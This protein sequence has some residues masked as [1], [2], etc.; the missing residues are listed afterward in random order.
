METINLKESA[1]ALMFYN[2]REKF[3]FDTIENASKFESHLK[4]DPHILFWTACATGLSGKHQQAIEKLEGLKTNHRHLDYAIINALIWLHEQSG[5]VDNDEMEVLERNLNIAKECT[6][7]EA[8]LL[9]AR[10]FLLLGRYSETIQNL[11]MTDD[12][13]L[14]ENCSIHLWLNLKAPDFC[15][16]NLL[17]HKKTISTHATNSNIDYLMAQA[18]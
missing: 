6:S 3:Y 17:N 9:S 7:S 14:P 4:N 10:L 8:A 18:K 16:N 2:L 13:E 11:Q 12:P 15:I 1:M 5:L